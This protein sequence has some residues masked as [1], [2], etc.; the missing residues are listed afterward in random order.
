MKNTERGSWLDND[1]GRKNGLVRIIKK[2][3]IQ[4]SSSYSGA[5]RLEVKGLRCPSLKIS[6]PD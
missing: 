6:Y 4:T 1:Q 3:L 2:G 5:W